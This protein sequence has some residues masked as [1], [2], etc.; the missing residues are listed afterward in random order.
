MQYARFEFCLPAWLKLPSFLAMTGWQN[1]ASTLN[2]PHHLAWNQPPETVT[3]W[4]ILA[5]S[6]HLGAVMRYIAHFN[7]GRE[8]WLDFYPVKQRL[9]DGAYTSNNGVA[10]VDVGGGD[11]CQ[12][13]AFRKRFP[14]LPGR[15]I[16]QDLSH[17]LP[18]DKSRIDGIEFMEHN[19]MT[20]QPIKGK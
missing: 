15:Y 16:V 12:T 8:D 17:V 20:E 5:N 9:I 14:M 1:P 3:I 10:M 13:K 18:K 7:E 19:F 11:G 4:E 6:P 2:T